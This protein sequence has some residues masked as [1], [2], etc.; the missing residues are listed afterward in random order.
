MAT[1]TDA[2]MTGHLRS[3]T[4]TSITSLGGVAAG[5]L[6]GYFASGPTDRLGLVIL[7]AMTLL[8]LGIMR[9]VGVDVED[10]SAKDH[11][12]NAFMTFSLWYVTWGVLLTSGVSF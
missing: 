11:L 1:E 9:V 7:L 8:N 5:L 4:V 3:V 12:F 2:G 10:F 6:S